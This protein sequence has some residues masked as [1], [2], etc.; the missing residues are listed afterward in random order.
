MAMVQTK[1]I[2]VLAAAVCLCSCST[3][4]YG[5]EKTE[6]AGR[7]TGVTA[8]QTGTIDS[9]YHA[10]NGRTFGP[11]TSVYGVA[12]VILRMRPKMISLTS[13]VIGR[14]PGGMRRGYPE[15]DLYDWAADM[16]GELVE[17]EIGKK[18]DMAFMNGG[19]IRIDMPKGDVKVEDIL[20]MFPF[21]NS[22]VYL[23]MKGSE[24]LGLLNKLASSKFQPLSGVK[25]V[26]SDGKVISAEIGGEPLDPERYY[27]VATIDFLL[28]GGDGFFLADHA[29]ECI[30]AARDIKDLIIPL[31][32]E[33]YAAG[34]LIEVTQ[35]NRIIIRE[36]VR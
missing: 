2:A 19:G 25:V 27:G 1:I 11:E 26:V 14:C 7:L 13:G 29:V 16:I 31:M 10:P 4:R 17:K 24:I 35:R 5:W 32:R 20:A 15:S 30:S 12:D 21:H 22:P 18:V 34:Q 3:Y 8:E 23:S 33:K 9:V 28:D 6:V 36:D